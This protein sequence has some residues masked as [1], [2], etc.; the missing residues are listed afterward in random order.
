MITLLPFQHAAVSVTATQTQRGKPWCHRLQVSP[1]PPGT[2]QLGGQS[3][4]SLEE[5]ARGGSIKSLNLRP[6]PGPAAVLALPI[7]RPYQGP[8]LVLTLPWPGPD[9]V[10]LPQRSGRADPGKGQGK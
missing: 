4:K 9:P 5:D 7:S 8:T 3:Q 1:P 10:P 6:F 2:E